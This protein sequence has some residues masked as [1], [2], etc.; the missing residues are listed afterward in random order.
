[1]PA[2]KN[3]KLQEFKDSMVEKVREIGKKQIDALNEQEIKN[4]EELR[5]QR[6]F[7][8]AEKAENEREAN[9][10]AAYQR[11]NE[12]TANMARSIQ[13]YETLAAIFGGCIAWLIELQ[14]VIANSN[15][16]KTIYEAPIMGSS[17]ISSEGQNFSAK[18]F[19]SYNTAKLWKI[20]NSSLG[21]N[22]N[23]SFNRDAHI[24]NIN[25][26]I[27]CDAH[28][29]FCFN[30]SSGVDEGKEAEAQELAKEL[31]AKFLELK[32]YSK[33]PGSAY[34]VYSDATGKVLTHD[35]FETFRSELEQKVEELTDNHVHSLR[36]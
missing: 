5:A 2:Q 7:A 4:I 6:Q 27:E 34:E 14:T 32:G 13:G 8:K 31:L 10:R 35:T 12:Q 15:V 26:T 36:P 16:L 19:V 22:E 28:N 20:L 1:M 9:Y 33:Q 17:K 3:D 30:F 11:L 18:E 21:I 29:K 24:P 23:P 25:L